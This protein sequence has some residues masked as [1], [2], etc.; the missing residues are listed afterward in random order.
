M[1]VPRTAHTLVRSAPCN[2]KGLI[3]LEICMEATEP[4][5]YSTGGGT[6]YVI[7]YA[8]IHVGMIADGMTLVTVAL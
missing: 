2:Y 7:K 1:L 5:L 8:T 3:H 6:S 4:M